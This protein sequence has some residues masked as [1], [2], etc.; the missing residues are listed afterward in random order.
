MSLPR[1][2]GYAAHPIQPTYARLGVRTPEEDTQGRPVLF[3]NRLS[4]RLTS[5]KRS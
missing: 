1:G 2:K 4:S 5:K 3:T